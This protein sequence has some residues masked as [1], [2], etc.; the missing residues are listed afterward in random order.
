MFLI[1]YLLYK[2][3][4]ICIIAKSNEISFNNVCKNICITVIPSVL[5]WW[6]FFMRSG[7]LLLLL[8]VMSISA[9]VLTIIKSKKSV[10][11]KLSVINILEW[12]TICVPTCFNYFDRPL[13]TIGDLDIYFLFWKIY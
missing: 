2:I 4:C 11:N 6:S 3:I 8:L 5:F 12:A 7:G 10:I 1:V 9:Y 13:F